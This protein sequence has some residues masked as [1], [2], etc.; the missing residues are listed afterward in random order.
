MEAQE[1]SEAEV[2]DEQGMDAYM[3]EIWTGI[4]ATRR[5]DVA[6]PCIHAQVRAFLFPGRSPQVS[7]Q[8]MDF[9]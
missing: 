6:S 9:G 5:E 8:S 1:K 7:L 3:E 4:V 2:H